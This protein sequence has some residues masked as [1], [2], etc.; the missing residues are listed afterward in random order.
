MQ[1]NL[2]LL[3]FYKVPDTMASQ[4][5]LFIPFPELKFEVDKEIERNVDGSK[6]IKELQKKSW[7][8]FRQTPRLV[9]LHTN[10]VQR[11]K[12]VL[13]TKRCINR[14]NCSVLFKNDAL[15]FMSVLCNQLGFILITMQTLSSCVF[16]NRAFSF[17]LNKETIYPFKPPKDMY[18]G[19]WETEQ[20]EIPSRWHRYARMPVE[21]SQYKKEGNSGIKY[22]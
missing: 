11:Q 13:E 9:E 8:K 17:S 21:G 2:Q 19:I 3:K 6:Q 5:G 20:Y 15:E 7:G 4:Y 10:T 14:K 22:T 12:N 1:C 18:F 16:K